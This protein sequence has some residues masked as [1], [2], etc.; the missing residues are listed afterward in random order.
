MVILILFYKV[1][2]TFE[3]LMVRNPEKSRTITNKSRQIMKKIAKNQEHS[4]KIEVK[5]ALGNSIRTV[6]NDENL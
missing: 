3:P 1:F 5:L 4:R 6:K 2:H